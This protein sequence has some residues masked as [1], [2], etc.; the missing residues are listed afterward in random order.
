MNTQLQQSIISTLAY[1]D[2]FDHPLTASELYRFL[3]Q[4][5]KIK[6]LD[7][8]LE[9][10]YLPP[11]IEYSDG[12][13][14]LSGRGKAVDIRRSKTGDNDRKNGIAKKAGK[15]IRWVPFVEAVLLCNNTAFEMAKENSDID[16][17]II[18]RNK[19]MWI[20]R[21][22]VTIILSLF[23]LRRTKR[24]TK[25]RICLSFY[26]TSDNLDFSKLK[27]TEP[28]VGL[29]YWIMQFTP[30]YDPSNIHHKIMQKNQWIKQYLPNAFSSSILS[31]RNR[32][33]NGKWSKLWK[34]FFEKMWNSDYGDLIENQARAIQKFKM[35]FNFT[36]VQN[37]PD[38]RVIISDQILKF[39]EGD[40]RVE[41]KEIWGQKIL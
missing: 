13:Y 35:K 1:F 14:Y 34:G 9:L 25:N 23:R 33:D 30:L 8:L 17:A 27:I 11:S 28:D 36:S 19:R 5:P 39:H 10:D 15:K 38:T 6:Y 41:Y 18:V 31:Y 20:T 16:V 7:F 24:K 32:V 3:Y 4:P 22:F 12:F 2:Y 37:E 21:F 29:I 40:R 26:T